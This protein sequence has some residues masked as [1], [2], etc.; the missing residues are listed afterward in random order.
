M[1]KYYNILLIYISMLQILLISLLLRYSVRQN[2]QRRKDLLWLTCRAQSHTAKKAWWQGREAC[3]Q[4]HH[5]LE[6]HQDECDH[7]APFYFFGDTRT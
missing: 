1:L 6:T 4:R 2:K 3:A 7:L 5:S